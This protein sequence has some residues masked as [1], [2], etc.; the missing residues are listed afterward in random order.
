MKVS[1]DIH[2]PTPEEAEDVKEAKKKQPVRAPDIGADSLQVLRSLDF[3][4]EYI[5]E[6]ISS[7]VVVAG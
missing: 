2:G 4:E 3:E 1:D 6:L 7:D 5:Q